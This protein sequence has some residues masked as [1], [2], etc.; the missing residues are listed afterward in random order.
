MKT[1]NH[2]IGIDFYVFFEWFHLDDCTAGIT[3]TTSDLFS[4]IFNVFPFTHQLS[5][6]KYGIRSA[7]DRIEGTPVL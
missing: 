1:L 2:R 7:V 3:R 4:F 5:P 6:P